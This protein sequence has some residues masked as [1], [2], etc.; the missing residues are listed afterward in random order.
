MLNKNFRNIMTGF[1]GIFRN[2]PNKIVYN[3]RV[4]QGKQ[5]FFTCQ[6]FQIEITKVI[7]HRENSKYPVNPVTVRGCANA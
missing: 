5:G 3:N 4:S 1:N 2:Y 7:K 6:L